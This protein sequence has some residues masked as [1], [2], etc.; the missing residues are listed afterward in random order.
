M[1]ERGFTLMEMIVVMVLLGILSVY[2]ASRLGNEGLAVNAAAQELVEAIRYA[3][4]RSMSDTGAA[5]FAIA[6]GA[7]GFRVTQGSADVVNPM[8]GAT[9]YTDDGWAGKGISTNASI[10]LEFD[11]RGE[12]LNRATGAS[13]GVV[14]VILTETGG[15]TATVVLQPVTG[16]ARVQ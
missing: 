2:V 15:D 11:G 14:T 8:T 13:P 4:Q 5:R 7:G 9:P 6:I 10:T 16:Y 12:P 3:Q 1:K